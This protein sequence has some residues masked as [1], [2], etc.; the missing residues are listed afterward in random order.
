M[1]KQDDKISAQESITEVFVKPWGG[2]A[3]D[4]ASALRHVV[5]EITIPL[6]PPR[7]GRGRKDSYSLT[8]RS[9]SIWSQLRRHLDIPLAEAFRSYRGP[10]AS[11][12][13][14]GFCLSAAGRRPPKWRIDNA[15]WVEAKRAGDLIDWGGLIVPVSRSTPKNRQKTSD[16]DQ[17]LDNVRAW[18]EN[19]R[20]VIH[21]S[22]VP[23]PGDVSVNGHL[24]FCATLDTIR[25]LLDALHDF[26]PQKGRDPLKI[27]GGSRPRL[28]DAVI[29]RQNDG[30][31]EL[32]WRHTMRTTGMTDQDTPVNKSRWLSDRFCSEHNPSD[33]SSRYRADQR[34]KEAFQQELMALR[35]RVVKSAFDVQFH[36][37]HSADVQEIR[38]AAYDL[39][40]AR[41]RPLTQLE[42]PSLQESV[43]R[44]YQQ[45]MR[46][47]DIARQLGTTRQSVFRAIRHT[48]KLLRTRQ[49]EQILNPSS[50]ESWDKSED[51]LFVQSVA[52]FHQDGYTATQIARITGRFRHTV[53]SV[54]RWLATTSPSAMSGTE[55]WH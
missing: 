12:L 2:C 14:T 18:D 47:A 3:P 24:Q 28:P 5:D 27:H 16:A 50:G 36:P 29:R 34:Y 25:S 42:K 39:V 4:V 1:K 23:L 41:L 26:R 43:W 53:L 44:L 11:K 35:L 32:C 55:T 6:P 17:V 49:Q 51:S 22:D 13:L 46:Q 52:A 21:S 45:G 33:P 19:L 37:P 15:A 31:C 40:H 8:S 30:C 10:W 38:K 48:E 7:E 54:L 20:F 9:P